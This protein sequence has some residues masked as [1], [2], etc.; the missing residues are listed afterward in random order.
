MMSDD[1]GIETEGVKELQPHHVNL[2]SGGAA[3]LT[4]F[5]EYKANGQ[6]GTAFLFKVRNEYALWVAKPE[7]H[8]S[9]C[10]LI[11]NPHERSRPKGE[12][13][14][15]AQANEF[16]RDFVIIHIVRLNVKHIGEESVNKNLRQ[17]SLRTKGIFIISTGNH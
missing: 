1:K 7:Q 12:V 6:T 9:T 5:E 3:P 11:V 2:R 10:V 14:S 4:R 13:V 15:V 8:V 17:T 16:L